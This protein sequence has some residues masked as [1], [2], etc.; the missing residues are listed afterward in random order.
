MNNKNQQI[1]SIV[2]KINTK[3]IASYPQHP[4]SK[5]LRQIIGYSKRIQDSNNEEETFKLAV[6]LAYNLDTICDPDKT[7]YVKSE[8]EKKH[9]LE[10]SQELFMNTLGEKK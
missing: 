3:K 5:T 8:E 9:W 4:E 7:G 10:L 6:R 2:A 1:K